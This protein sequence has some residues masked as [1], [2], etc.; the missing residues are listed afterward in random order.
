MNPQHLEL[1]LLCSR[2]MTE[3]YDV[4]FAENCNAVSL[5]QIRGVGVGT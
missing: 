4:V 5:Q 2:T 3:K 1:I